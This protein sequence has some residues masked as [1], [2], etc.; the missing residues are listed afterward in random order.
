MKCIG[1]YWSNEGPFC[2]VDKNV[3]P[4]AEGRGSRRAVGSDPEHS[5]GGGEEEKEGGGWGYSWASF[6]AIL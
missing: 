5:S 3:D 4:R 6:P 2:L 1:V